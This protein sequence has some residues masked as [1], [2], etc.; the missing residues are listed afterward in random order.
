MGVVLG[1]AVILLTA[2][3]KQDVEEHSDIISN[4]HNEGNVE[5]V[6]ENIESVEENEDENEEE[7]SGEEKTEEPEELIALY[8]TDRVNVRDRPSVEAEKI[9]TLNAYETVQGMKKEDGWW[10][11]WLDGQICYI[12]E[13]FLR[14][15]REGE[16]GF[17]IVIDAGHQA[18][19]NSEQEPVGPGAD[20][21]K[22]KVSSGTAG[23]TSG[24]KEYELTLMVSLKLQKELE[25]RGYEVI[26]VRTTND[27]N[28]SNSERAVIANQAGAD[29][30]IRVH[31]NGAED[32]SAN[33]AMTICQTEDNPY[34]GELYPESREL[35][36]KVLDELV[37]ATGCRKEYVWETDTMSGINWCQVPA[38]I[39]EM[40]YM[41]NPEEDARLATE[42][43]QNKIVK[44]I[45][46][47]IDSFLNQNLEER[48][49]R[50]LE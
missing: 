15:K 10:S 20:E 17:L 6:P 50:D 19:G 42:E 45:A 46:N 40:G 39:V 18:K 33:G 9:A 32:T 5:Q 1:M 8:T 43:Y 4:G 27:V 21:T 11:I 12:A 38:T 16:N 28:I 31:A 29:A 44:G 23:M 3:S 34:N 26:M 25:N 13:D 37:S 24:L 22:A 49:G 2:C 48:T 47:G 7:K 14:E 30:F 35:A 36:E 41:T